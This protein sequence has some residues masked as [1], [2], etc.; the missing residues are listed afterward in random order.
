[1]STGVAYSGQRIILG[2]ENHQ[3]S[4]RTNLNRKSGRQPVGVWRRLKA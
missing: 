3:P 2:V 1:M 4:A